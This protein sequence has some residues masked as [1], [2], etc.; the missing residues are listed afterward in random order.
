MK[1]EIGLS[2]HLKIEL[3][4]LQKNLEN[5]LVLF[6]QLKSDAIILAKKS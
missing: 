5:Y 3:I 6:V 1:K 4:T 2:I